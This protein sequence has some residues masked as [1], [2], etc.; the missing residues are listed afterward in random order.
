MFGGCSMDSNAPYLLRC[1]GCGT[2]NRIPAQKKDSGAKCG[3]CGLPLATDI[4]SEGHP[5][6]VTDADFAGNVLKSPLPVLLDCWAPWCGPCQMIGPIIE[7]LAKTW[8]GRVRV[9]KLNVDENTRTAASFNIQSIPTMLIFDNG[10]LKDTLAGAH[11]KANI[12]R[13]M[14]PYI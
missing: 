1:T 6:V 13:K 8:K 12:V 14:E 10:T 7:E 2:K 9:C 3:K 4:L 11:P 5:V